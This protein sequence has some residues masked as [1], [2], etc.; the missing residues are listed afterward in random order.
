MDILLCPLDALSCEN[1]DGHSAGYR[2]VVDLRDPV[3]CCLNLRQV[4]YTTTAVD[5]GHEL[6]LAACRLGSRVSPTSQS[7][8][9]T[10]TGG[11]ECELGCDSISGPALTIAYQ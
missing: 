7:F 11:F 9:Q 1:V 5:D 8:S 2:L 3:G 4:A 10:D 6:D